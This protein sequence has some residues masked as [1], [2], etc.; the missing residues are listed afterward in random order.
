VF[1]SDFGQEQD[2]FSSVLQ[3]CADLFKFF[4]SWDVL[5]MDGLPLGVALPARADAA[6]CTTNPRCAL[7]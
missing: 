3:L 2:A 1:G 4:A 7:T 5:A 6:R